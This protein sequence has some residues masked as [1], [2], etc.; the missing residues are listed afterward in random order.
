MEYCSADNEGRRLVTIQAEPLA[1]SDKK[2]VPVT[3]FQ[4]AQ[5][6]NNDASA[7]WYLLSDCL[8]RELEYP[9]VIL[10]NNNNNYGFTIGLLW[11]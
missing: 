2:V 3:G 10:A 1:I 6:D 8:D 4:Q 11:G 7:D 9:I 5:T